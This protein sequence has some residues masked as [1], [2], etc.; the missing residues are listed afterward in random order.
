MESQ[1]FIG[2]RLGKVCWA[3]LNWFGAGEGTE[4]GTEALASS[5]AEVALYST[6]ASTWPPTKS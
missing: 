1:P 2:A 4:E 3:R 6:I 5:M